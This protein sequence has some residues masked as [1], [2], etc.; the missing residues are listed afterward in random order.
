MGVLQELNLCAN[1]LSG[2]WLIIPRV[3]WKTPAD[4]CECYPRRGRQLSEMFLTEKRKISPYR[5]TWFLIGQ[6]FPGSKPWSRALK[7]S[8][9][10]GLIAAMQHVGCTEKYQVNIWDFLSRTK[11]RF[12]YLMPS[13]LR[14]NSRSFGEPQP[15][16]NSR[17]MHQRARW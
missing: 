7:F 2:R 13:V 16:A 5:S 12:D 1:S 10:V 8:N 9:T 17:L 6:V 11:K 15:A 14:I 4:D 3:L